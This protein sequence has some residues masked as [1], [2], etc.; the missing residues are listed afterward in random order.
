MAWL[1]WIS[2]R[3]CSI[4]LDMGTEWDE[5]Q[6]KCLEV[7]TEVGPSL[8]SRLVSFLKTLNGAT[9]LLKGWEENN[10]TVTLLLAPLTN[11]MRGSSSWEIDKSGSSD[12]QE[13]ATLYETQNVIKR[14]FSSNI[15]FLVT[16][17]FRGPLSLVSTTEELLGTKSS[18][19][20]LEISEYGRRG[21]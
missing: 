16:I 20:G 3:H 5:W 2:H 15:F 9:E 8:P 19:S 21:P 13:T 12:N 14:E 17:I 4:H 18:G 10:A 11:P 7:N 6:V 1:L